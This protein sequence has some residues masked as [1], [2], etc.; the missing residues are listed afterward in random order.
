MG[1]I[2]PRSDPDIANIIKKIF[3]SEITSIQGQCGYKWEGDDEPGHSSINIIAL[4]FPRM[5]PW[6]VLLIET[7]ESNN[8]F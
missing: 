7:D 4:S 5:L 1:E 6:I 8:T 3:L 2:W